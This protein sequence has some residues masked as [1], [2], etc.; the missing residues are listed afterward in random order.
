MEKNT[1]VSGGLI[2]LLSVFYPFGHIVLIH[3]QLS[4]LHFNVQSEESKTN[5]AVVEAYK[6]SLALTTKLCKELI[7]DMFFVVFN[8]RHRPVVS[9]SLLLSSRAL[10]IRTLSQLDDGTSISALTS[11]VALDK[12][13]LFGYD[14]FMA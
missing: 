4:S 13:K 3:Y 7:I 11:Q 10:T 8:I 2:A 9:A 1:S 14:K 5:D 12:G 6:I